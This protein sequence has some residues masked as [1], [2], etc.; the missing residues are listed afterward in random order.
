MA[1]RPHL[2]E[3]VNRLTED[4]QEN[5]AVYDLLASSL[6]LLADNVDPFVVTRHYELVL[7]TLLGYKPELYRCVSCHQELTAI[8]NAFS[9]RLGGALC[10]LCRAADAGSR[11]LSVNAQKFLRTLDRHG[12]AAAVKLPLDVTISAELEGLLGG[13]LRHYAERRPR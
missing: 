4:R 7:L 1:M 9:S 3:V 13:L 10:P 12:L 5:V 6:R 11:V 2:V 8:P